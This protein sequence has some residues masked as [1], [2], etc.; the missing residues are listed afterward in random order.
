L[1][2]ALFICLNLAGQ[3]LSSSL[4]L[5]VGPETTQKMEFAYSNTKAGKEYVKYLFRVSDDESVIFDIGV[6]SDSEIQLE[7]PQNAVVANPSV[8]NNLDA[9]TRKHHFW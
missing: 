8:W 6:E 5:V 9:P 3:K 1:A 2:F 4:N 7:K